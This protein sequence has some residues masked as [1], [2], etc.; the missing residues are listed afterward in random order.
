MTWTK[1]SDD[2]GVDCRDLSDA[3]FRTHVEGLSWVMKRE[4]GGYLD[5]RDIR[6]FGESPHAEMAIAE[7]VACGW[8]SIEGQGYRIHHHMEH[9]PEPDLVARRR[10]L[11]AER[12]RK[13]RRKKAGLDDGNAVTECVTRVGTGRDGTGREPLKTTRSYKKELGK[14]P[15]LGAAGAAEAVRIATRWR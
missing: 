12:V 9:Q 10:E 5:A 8:W 4:T 2:F 11:T 1:L 6:R 13:H 3:A 14:S 7:L 15:V